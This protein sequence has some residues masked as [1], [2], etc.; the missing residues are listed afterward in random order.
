MDYYANSNDNKEITLCKATTSLTS[1]ISAVTSVMTTYFK[2]KFPEDYFKQTYIS[3][4]MA[5][6]VIGKDYYQVQQRPYLFVQPQ[7][8]L[9]NGVMNELPLW[10]TASWYILNNMRENYQMIFEDVESGIRIFTIPNRIKIN[11]NTGIRLNTELQAW[12]CLNYIKQNFEST[13]FYYL[14]N[15]NISNEIPKFIIRNICQR[16]NWNINNKYDREKLQ[17]Y[18][19]KHSF[20][21][22][23]ETIDMSTGNTS[24][25][26]NHPENILINY[27]DQA[28]SD[29]TMRDRIVQLSQVNFNFTAEVWIPGHF[30]IELDKKERF[31][32][33]PL[34]S[35]RPDEF[36]KDT[37]FKFTSIINVDYIPYEKQQKKLI[38]KRNFIPDVNVEYDQLD[39]KLVMPYGLM[40]IYNYL[41][42]NDI[43]LNDLFIIDVYINGRMIDK[44]LYR[45][46][47]KDFILNTYNPMLNTTYTVIIYA[48]MDVFNKIDLLMNKNN[49]KELQGY[50][51][52]LKNK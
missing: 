24:W 46:D 12:N 16:L 6:Q 38:V 30:L 14:N 19:L 7:F 36:N 26:Y 35:E 39:L 40:N 42:N 1:T 18:L 49:E 25:F 43:K 5:A 31:N 23:E 27:V 44:S 15:V 41:K 4:S 13:G 47:Y 33:F 9:S 8:D 37:N 10:H 51:K 28:T 2:S 29:K 20:N 34:I 17:E 21:A 32:H 48:D 22:I 3:T 50:L 45:I 52:Y 11:F